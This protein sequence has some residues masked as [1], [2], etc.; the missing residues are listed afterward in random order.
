MPLLA[1][2]PDPPAYPFTQS[3]LLPDI[4]QTSGPSCIEP[5]QV[6][7]DPS[8]Q[9]GPSDGFGATSS[10]STLRPEKRR[11]TDVAWW[12]PVPSSYALE[13][14]I[15]RQ[16][17]T[18]AFPHL[19]LRDLQALRNSCKALRC[20]VEAMRPAAWLQVARCASH[21]QSQ[22]QVQS[23]SL[24]SLSAG[25]LTHATRRNTVPEDHP[26]CHSSA[27]GSIPAQAAQLAQLHRR[28]RSGKVTDAGI[29]D[30]PLADLAR[31]CVP[32]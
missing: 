3:A 29:F 22:S 20:E 21:V 2:V 30:D 16:L 5:A 7:M 8:W 9:P 12:K 4:P 17:S 6:V 23:Q 14:A 25:V 1:R 26:L 15:R 28:L 13:T 24:L 32:P 11:R 27:A 18:R 19:A 31:A 10:R